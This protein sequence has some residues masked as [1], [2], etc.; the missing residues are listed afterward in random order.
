MKSPA[1]LILAVLAAAVLGFVLLNDGEPD[2]PDDLENGKSEDGV[3][4]DPKSGV[5]LNAHAGKT[6]KPSTGKSDSASKESGETPTLEALWKQAPSGKISEWDAARL[7]QKG[8][9]VSHSSRVA[10]L[11]DAMAGS[12]W[13]NE[14]PFRLSLVFGE[15]DLPWLERLG[16]LYDQEIRAGTGADGDMAPAIEERQVYYRQVL[17]D[18]A[19]KRVRGYPELALR[20]EDGTLLR[21]MKDPKDQAWLSAV[22]G[23]VEANTLWGERAVPR[24]FRK[25]LAA[26]D[27]PYIA[28][29]SQYLMQGAATAKSKAERLRILNAVCAEIRDYLDGREERK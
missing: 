29:R 23:L 27:L 1:I 10:G 13:T 4:P 28:R 14:P 3:E 5:G 24:R 11:L 21:D 18:V 16:K 9:A 19:A 12:L 6:A 2:R 26:R 17:E 25:L 20:F 22:I 7:G 8:V 15:S